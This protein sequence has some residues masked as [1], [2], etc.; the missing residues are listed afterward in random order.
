MRIRTLDPF[1]ISMQN[2][3]NLTCDLI[4]SGEMQHLKVCFNLIENLL[5]NGEPLVV[6]AIRFMLIPSV[7]AVINVCPLPSAIT[8]LLPQ[9][10][11]EEYEKTH[12]TINFKSD[13]TEFRIYLN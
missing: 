10:F 7:S 4:R 6:N 8:K 9:L 5:E 12:G 2:F 1:Y 3:A 11:R 13:L